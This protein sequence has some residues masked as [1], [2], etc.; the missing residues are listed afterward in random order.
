MKKRKKFNLFYLLRAFVHH[1]KL[2]ELVAAN[3][4]KA[5]YDLYVPVLNQQLD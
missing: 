2:E 4:V 5:T 1:H 3:F